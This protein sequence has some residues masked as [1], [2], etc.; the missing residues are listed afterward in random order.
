M[1]LFDESVGRWCI[2]LEDM[3]MLARCQNALGSFADDAMV[4]ERRARLDDACHQLRR[5]GP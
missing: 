1:L 2:N 3:L 4:P 5:A